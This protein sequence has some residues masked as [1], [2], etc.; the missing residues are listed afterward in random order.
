MLHFSLC[1][2]PPG[3]EDF[4]L[5]LMKWALQQFSRKDPSLKDRINPRGLRRLR[6]ACER[7]KRALSASSSAT[8]EVDS[9]VD[10]LDLQVTLSRA[11]FEDLLADHF[12]RCLLPVAQVL[13]DCQIPKQRVGGLVWPMTHLP[14]GSIPPTAFHA[15]CVV[16]VKCPCRWVCLAEALS[17]RIGTWLGRVCRE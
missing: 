10:G 9:L 12:K 3:G 5:I 6:T 7:A 8:I 4:D 15:F 14:F 13:T 11:R 17:Q 1:A 2:V 16:S